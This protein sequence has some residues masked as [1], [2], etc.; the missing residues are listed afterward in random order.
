MNPPASL[1]P[2]IFGHDGAAVLTG[3]P[4]EEGLLVRLSNFLVENFVVKPLASNEVQQ[5]LV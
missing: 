3:R 4:R 1:Y 5:L 2:H